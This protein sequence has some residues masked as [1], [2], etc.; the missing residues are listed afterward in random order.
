MR[1][2][3]RWMTDENM[4]FPGRRGMTKCL[5]SNCHRHWKVM[6]GLTEIL[7]I[8]S[9]GF[10]CREIGIRSAVLSPINPLECRKNLER[11][12]FRL[13]QHQSHLSPSRT[14]VY[15][16][17]NFQSEEGRLHDQNRYDLRCM[18]VKEVFRA[19]MMA[20]LP[21]KTYTCCIYEAQAAVSPAC[22]MFKRTTAETLL[23]LKS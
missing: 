18:L 13:L 23:S 6:C 12:D 8:D 21:E 5:K 20:F 16:P 3:Q 4:L 9:L 7:K 1:I 10:L 17:P 14:S 19:M 22:M 15:R 2:F 11:D